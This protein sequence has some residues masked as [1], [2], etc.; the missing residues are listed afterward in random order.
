MASSRKVAEIP[1]TWVNRKKRIQN[2]KK[3][4]K[5]WR[6]TRE[7]AKPRD[8]LGCPVEIGEL[9]DIDVVVIVAPDPRVVVI[10]V[11]IFETEVIDLVDA[12]DA[13]RVA[14]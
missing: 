14:F 13:V 1:V 10:T 12:V 11:V 5:V 8:T 6:W 2:V 7:E 9:V 4:T 3:M